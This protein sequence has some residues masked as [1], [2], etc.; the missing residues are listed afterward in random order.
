MKVGIHTL[1]CRVNTADSM[2]LQEAFRAHGAELVGKHDRADIYVL[3]SCTVTHTADADARKLARR[4][5]RSNPDAK[6]VVTGCYAQVSADELRAIAEIDLVVGNDGK[7]QLAATLMKAPTSALSPDT[8]GERSAAGS[9][10]ARGRVWQADVR[11]P[12]SHITAMP[13]S[14]T[15]PFLKV[16]DGCD[17]SCAF[18]IIPQ[19]RGVSR[20]SSVSDVI[21]QALRYADL[22]AAE[23]VLTGIHL[24]HWG[25]DLV[26]RQPFHAMVAQLAEALTADGRILRLRLGS[27]EPNEVTKELLDLVADHPLL[28]EHLHVPLQSGDDDTLKRMRRLYSAAQY[29]DVIEAVRDRMPS[30]AIGADV[31]VG[32]PGE[33]QRSYETTRK[34]LQHLDVTYLH[35]FPWSPRKG[36]PS[37]QMAGRIDD[38]DKAAR[39][40]ELI[41]LSNAKRHFFHRRFVG[42]QLEVIALQDEATAVRCLSRNYIPVRLQN[43]ATGQ[44]TVA[45]T[46]MTC[47]VVEAGA[48]RCLARRKN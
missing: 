46:V 9:K 23:L 21:D 34:L 28:C 5:K 32:H 3:N 14:R 7:P 11:P 6:V 27:V 16:Q 2:A 20:S 19:A 13:E 17:Y 29:R 10:R 36:T 47:K 42:R 37:A 8:T 4:F 33:D 48:E 22:G 25:R 24:G 40:Q 39:V 31:L 12:R 45:G 26:P 38:R 30:A 15:R 43:S 1:G 35:V 44:D 41:R 18:C